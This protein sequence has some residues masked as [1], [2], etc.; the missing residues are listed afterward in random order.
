MPKPRKE[1]TVT[2]RVY[3]PDKLRFN[4]LKAKLQKEELIKSDPQVFNYLLNLH[5]HV[6]KDLGIPN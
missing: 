1:K 6:A 3:G 4:R 2:F 5:D